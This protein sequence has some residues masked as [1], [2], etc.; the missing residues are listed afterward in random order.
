MTWL[1]T[2]I[3]AA[4]IIYSFFI[5]VILIE[6]V[7]DRRSRRKPEQKK[8]KE[9]L[10]PVTVEKSENKKI[11]KSKNQKIIKSPSDSR[12]P[13]AEK[14]LKKMIRRE[15][16]AGKKIESGLKPQAEAEP[17]EDP[18]GEEP[19]DDHGSPSV[20]KEREFE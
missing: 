4:L 3:T 5:V 6:Y 13:A 17:V 19:V 12:S 16:A 7:S 15:K 8:P 10:I 2:A 1:D 9:K 18:G 11:R 14:A 20:W